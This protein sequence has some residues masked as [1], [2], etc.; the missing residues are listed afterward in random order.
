MTDQWELCCVGLSVKI[1]TPKEHEQYALDEYIK[2][3]IN[4]GFKLK[5]DQA[6]QDTNYPRLL[7]EGWEPFCAVNSISMLH[8]EVYFRRKIKRK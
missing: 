6:Y 3:F 8:A 2:Q 1:D 7:I 5:G 4:P